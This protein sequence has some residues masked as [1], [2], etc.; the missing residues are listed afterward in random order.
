MVFC[1]IKSQ[2]ILPVVNSVGR[3][4]AASITIQTMVMAFHAAPQA[5]LCSLGMRAGGV[6][7][8]MHN[9]QAACH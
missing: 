3:A 6:W 2:E 4:T 1:L 7:R 8:E 9:R 5:H